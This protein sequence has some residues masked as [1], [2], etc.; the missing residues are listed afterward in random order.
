M[1][2]IGVGIFLLLLLIGFAVFN[3]RDIEHE[4]D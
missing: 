1:T 3:L 2:L 4:R